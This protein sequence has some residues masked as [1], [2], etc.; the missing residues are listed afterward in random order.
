MSCTTMLQLVYFSTNLVVIQ[1]EYTALHNVIMFTCTLFPAPT[2]VI[3][4][5]YL[6]GCSSKAPNYCPSSANGR[7]ISPHYPHYE[8]HK[9][10]HIPPG[11]GGG[12]DSAWSAAAGTQ[13]NKEV[14]T[15]VDKRPKYQAFG[16]ACI[17]EHVTVFW[18]EW[19][20]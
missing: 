8:M 16:P 13:V 6:Y 3:V 7:I 10:P 12:G 4:M 15:Y 17:L 14:H 9:R 2:I 18:S 20:R 5:P 1:V 11:G 19:L